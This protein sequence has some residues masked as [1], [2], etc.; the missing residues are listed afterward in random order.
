M[1]SVS[2]AQLDGVLFYSGGG[3]KLDQMLD[4]SHYIVQW[5]GDAGT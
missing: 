3:G 5:V 2:L 1:S 4:R